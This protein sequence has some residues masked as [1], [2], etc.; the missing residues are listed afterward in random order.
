MD[1]WMVRS[2][3]GELLARYAFAI[4]RKD[5]PGWLACFDKD[6]TYL[7]QTRENFNDGLPIG[8]MWD[9]RYARLQDRVKTVD[10]IWAGTAEDYQPRHLVQSL[11]VSGGEGGLY[12][13]VANFV[14][15]YTTNGG[16]SR[17]L[18]TGEY[19]D[20]VRIAGEQA[21][22]VSKKAILD[23]ITVPRYLVYPI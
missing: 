3:V 21:L 22:I 14:V 20:T 8:Y 1:K 2:M 9:D 23:Q 4:D 18:T 13:V 19:H 16:D 7:C 12:D 15:F 11:D 6:G 10:E 17:I 5:M